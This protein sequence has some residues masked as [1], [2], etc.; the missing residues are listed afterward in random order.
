MIYTETKEANEQ[1]DLNISTYKS[2]FE[3]H[4]FEECLDMLNPDA[5]VQHS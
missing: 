3:L 1:N 4:L 5:N 2:V